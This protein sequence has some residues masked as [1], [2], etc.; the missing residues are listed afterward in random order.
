M[1]IHCLADDRRYSFPLLRGTLSYLCLGHISR[2][3]QF[4]VDNA[5][6]LKESCRG[7][8]ACY[9]ALLNSDSVDTKDL[10]IA[11]EPVQEHQPILTGRRLAITI[12]RLASANEMR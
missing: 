3:L 6:L 7:P 5:S 9:K 11:I 4:C 2:H 12:Y 10:S 1:E 8:Q